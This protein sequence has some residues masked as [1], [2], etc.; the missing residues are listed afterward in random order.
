MGW[1]VANKFI[2][3]TGDTGSVGKF[4]VLLSRYSDRYEVTVDFWTMDR[5]CMHQ[6]VFKNLE[7]AR[8]EYTQVLSAVLRICQLGT[9]EGA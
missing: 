3:C 9:D 5:F 7:M 8:E 2:K 6:S 1:V 4:H